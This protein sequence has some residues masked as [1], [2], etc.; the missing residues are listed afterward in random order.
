MLN[1]TLQP[2]Y[3]IAIFEFDGDITAH[4][5]SHASSKID[6][7]LTLA[8]GLKGLIVCSEHW[9]QWQSYS[10]F[11]SHLQFIFSHQQYI[12]K[13]ALIS[14]DTSVELVG[15][16]LGMLLQPTIKLFPSN[17][18]EDSKYWILED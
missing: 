2:N 4:D 1:V 16:L 3:G 5:F 17:A 15:S 13:V 8:G 7:Y 10:A 9:P 11:T 6:G 12:N 18:L 14:D